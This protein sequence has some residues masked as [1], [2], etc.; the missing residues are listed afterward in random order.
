[1]AQQHVE[2]QDGMEAVSPMVNA[3]QSPPQRHVSAFSETIDNTPPIPVEYG[4]SSQGQYQD[5]K[6][7]PDAYAYFSA[8]E[9][10]EQQQYPHYGVPPPGPGSPPPQYAAAQPYGEK[11][12]QDVAANEFAGGTPPL[13]EKKI[14]GMRKRT[15]WIVLFIVVALILL[16]AGLGA[17]LGIGLN[18]KKDE[19][20]IA[21]PFCKEKPDLC[22]GGALDS[23]YFSQ[24]GAFNGSG[25]ALAGESWNNNEFRL[26]TIYYQHWT[27]DIRYMQYKKDRKW[28]GGTSS[29]TVAKNAK[30]GTAIS[31][32]AFTLN[33]TSYVHIYY[34]SK[35]NQ[36]N[37]R[38]LSNATNLWEN[39]P[40]N[41]MKLDVLDN[42]SVGLQACYKGSFYGDSDYKKLPTA[43][44]EQNKVP[45]TG[46]TG[47]NLW[48]ASDES[49]FQQYVWYSND[50]DAWVKVSPWTNKNVH[51]GV[52]C[53][54]WGA[55]SNTYTMMVNEN[56]STEIWWK[57]GNSTSVSS[58][59]HPVNAWTNSSLA[60]PNVD[61]TTSLGYTNYLYMQ[62]EDR[63][64][65]GFNVQY[66]AENTYL[67]DDQF[68]ISP[69]GVDEHAVSGT[70]LT[71]TSVAV[72]D[73]KNSSITLWDSLYVFVQTEGDDI[74]AYA[75][76]LKGGEWSKA[77]L[78]L[79]DD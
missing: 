13:Q 71:A 70:H 33:E 42:P 62:M 60:I 68:T 61:P 17:G 36:V 47:I 67:N 29:E 8:P 5:K 55:G 57:D 66:D 72:K 41:D 11:G 34:V 25:I 31:A 54:S 3:P 24:K 15:F 37:Q 58:D 35:D 78:T 44:G 64:I 22:I 40:I 48:F 12:K 23:R 65:K 9:A 73:D 18:K 38:I 21:D 30:N 75:R 50:E 28:V 39:G 59:K 16:A 32:V 53:F 2:G 1:M 51:A 43:N 46:S 74:T 49:T 20:I 26:F 7:Q 56:N 79:S 69:L 63:T 45:F 14:A 4:Q 76:P 19:Q 6:Y 27:G 10:V 52:G 77:L